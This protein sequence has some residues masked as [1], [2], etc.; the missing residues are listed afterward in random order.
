MALSVIDSSLAAAWLLDDEHHP[1]A[2]VTFNNLGED[3]GVVPMLWHFE[4]R[5]TLLMAERRRRITRPGI[6]ECLNELAALPIIT[7]QSTDLGTCLELARKH[8]LTFYDALYLELAVRRNAQL[9]TLDNALAH[10]ADAEG[11]PAP[12]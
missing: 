4:I 8:N 10:A 1:L 11:L 5:N 3:G 12:S 9:A 7:D 6:E 2:E